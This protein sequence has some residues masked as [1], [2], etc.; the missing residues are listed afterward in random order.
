MIFK[1]F[2]NIDLL[3]IG[4]K[5][6]SLA[7]FI[8][9]NILDSEDYYKKYK[10]LKKELTLIEFSYWCAGF[11]VFFP[12]IS[13]IILELL[14]FLFSYIFG[15]NIL[16]TISLAILFIPMFL[17]LTS[18]LALVIIYLY[19]DYKI[20]KRVKNLDMN[21]IIAVIYL[22]LLNSAGLPPQF[23]FK[24][25]SKFKEFGEV[26]IETKY[27]DRLLNLGVDLPT[28]LE[29]AIETCPKSL[30]K[31]LLEDM[32]EVI[33]GGGDLNTFFQQKMEVMIDIFKNR[34]KAFVDFLGIIVEIY[35]TLVIVGSIFVL[36]LT[37]VAAMLGAMDVNT[38]IFLQKFLIFFFIPFVSSLLVLVVKEANPFA[39]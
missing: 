27:I 23:S 16:I 38:V 3:K 14:W 13:T 19:P 25:M 11:T 30:W 20:Y 12:I 34:N 37:L 17:L 39:S 1:K 28:A 21:T 26:W 22:E 18:A 8:Y 4:Y 35:I 9:K 2:L 36:I 7:S 33:K 5:L 31:Q 29:K 24:I 10:L 32:K 6:K 15:F